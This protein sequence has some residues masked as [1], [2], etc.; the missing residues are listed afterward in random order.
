[1]PVVSVD[2]AYRDYRDFGMAVLEDR[3]SGAEYEF[4]QFA[5]NSTQ[6]PT[7]HGA[8]ELILDVCGRV[9]ASVVVLDGP[10]GWKD[11]SNGLAHSRLCEKLVNAPGKTGLPGVA[12]PGN[13]VGFIAFTIEVFD[14]LQSRGWRRF[15]PAN[16]RLDQLTVI[17]SL[18]LRAWRSLGLPCLPAKSRATRADMQSHWEELIG[19]GIIKGGATPTHDQLQALVAGLGGLGVLA[20][21][22]D[23]Y[24]ALGAKPFS[25]V[26]AWREGYIVSPA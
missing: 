25:L 18:P 4:L 2:L 20:G 23:R 24:E 8:A 15:D 21:A 10:Q 3:S 6:A 13:Y 19:L 1:V 7:P 16:W 14:A 9:G 12:K 17:E 22:P 5:N 11:P 26:E